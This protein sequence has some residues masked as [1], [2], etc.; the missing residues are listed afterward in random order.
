VKKLGREP[1][2]VLQV[3]DDPTVARESVQP[4]GAQA[5]RPVRL[6]L[7][8]AVEAVSNRHERAPHDGLPG[9]LRRPPHPEEL[10]LDEGVFERTVP[11]PRCRAERADQ[12]PPGE[13]EA[14]GPLE[15]RADRGLRAQYRRRIAE[16]EGERVAEVEVLVPEKET[17]VLLDRENGARELDACEEKPEAPFVG[18]GEVV[19]FALDRP[20]PG[21]LPS[22]T[23]VETHDRTVRFQGEPPSRRQLEGARVHSESRDLAPVRVEPGLAAR[24]VEEE[25]ASRGRIERTEAAGQSEVPPVAVAVGVVEQVESQAPTQ[26]LRIGVQNLARRTVGPLRHRERHLLA[27]PEEVLLLDRHPVVALPAR[28][29][30]RT[31]KL[32][33]PRVVRSH[34]HVDLALAA[35]DRLGRDRHRPE[36]LEKTQV[37]LGLR[38]LRRVEEVP[39]GEQELPADDLR[40]RH[41]VNPV[42]DPC[43]KGGLGILED[44]LGLDP[45]TADAGAGLRWSRRGQP[46]RKENAQN[47]DAGP[48][49]PRAHRPGTRIPGGNAA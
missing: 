48:D 20:E 5:A 43:Q 33:G 10:P 4:V 27:Q 21:L 22:I 38:R 28:P 37:P 8:L 18:K 3:E 36:D 6:H 19:G 25:R 42:G 24:L 26:E 1:D 23:R 46:D 49:S 34:H 14:P 9:E 7:D 40:P 44:V 47:E 31:G 35:L 13:R 45:D 17:H 15:G 12:E 29:P 30:E 16:L 32:R 39:L 2:P 11:S 41:A